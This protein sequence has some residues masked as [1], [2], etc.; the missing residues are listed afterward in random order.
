MSTIEQQI[1]EAIARIGDGNLGK[2]VH[3]IKA[4]EAAEIN[5][6]G[7]DSQIKYLLDHHLRKEH[8]PW[9]WSR[10]DVLSILKEIIAE[11]ESGGM[12]KRGD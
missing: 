4:D 7:V 2:I 10:S 1:G 3:E 12:E 6:G 5:K 11:R 9:P 8:R